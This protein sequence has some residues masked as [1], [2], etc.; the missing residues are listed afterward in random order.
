[1]SIR[2]N[3]AELLQLIAEYADAGLRFC[4]VV[5]SLI[6]EFRV[7]ASLSKFVEELRLSTK[8]VR[9]NLEQ[10][11]S[12]QDYAKSFIVGGNDSNDELYSLFESIS[13]RVEY[14]CNKLIAEF[15]DTSA[16]G[17]PKWVTF[18]D[19]RIRFTRLINRLADYIGTPSV[20]FYHSAGTNEEKLLDEFDRRLGRSMEIQ[21]K[22]EAELMAKVE[23]V[24]AQLSQI[25][26]LANQKLKRIDQLSEEGEQALGNIF[27]EFKNEIDNKLSDLGEHIANVTGQSISTERMQL[28]SGE[29]RT[30]DFL[31]LSSFFLMCVTFVLAFFL[32]KDLSPDQV[33]L[34]LLMNKVTLIILLTLPSAY[35]ARESTKHRKREF[36]YTETAMDISAVEPYIASMP[37]ERQHALKCEL[38]KQIFSRTERKSSAEDTYPINTQELLLEIIKKL[39]MPKGNGGNSNSE[40]T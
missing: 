6:G 34:P 39:E 13:S 8:E 22:N 3:D 32:F 2:G 15:G 31:R 33:S 17:M 4:S 18:E 19:A 29:R 37:K 38:A 28:A 40:K 35:L 1:M 11:N 25:E 20:S 14:I 26:N 27:L 5:E 30:A 24:E 9:Q 10:I 23:S 12:S 7:D 16:T 21:R 36:E